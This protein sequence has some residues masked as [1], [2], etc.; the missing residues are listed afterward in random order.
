MDE[1]RAEFEAWAKSKG[2]PKDGWWIR[3]ID[4][5]GYSC[6][7]VDMAWDAWQAATQRQQERIAE[8]E[9]DLKFV[10]RWA[11][12]HGAKPHTTAEEALSVIQHYPPITR[13]TRGYADGVVP[14]TFDP[15]SRIAELEAQVQALTR[16]AVVLA[17]KAEMHDAINRA[18]ADLPEGYDLHIELEKNAG[19]VR[20]YL[21]DSDADVTDFGSDLGFVGEINAAIDAAI[22]AGK[23]EVNG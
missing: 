10:E 16:K 21:L 11:N 19:T 17:E 20:L 1:Q 15:Y 12:H 23:G 4:D 14:D 8:L 7:A 13:I 2:A 18:C 9:R 5:G 22:A 3:Q 6:H